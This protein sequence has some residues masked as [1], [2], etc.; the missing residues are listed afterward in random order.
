MSLRSLF[1]SAAVRLMRE[2]WGAK[3]VDI[4]GDERDTGVQELAEEL[5]AMILSEE[6][7]E[8]F[9]PIVLNNNT[10]GPAIVIRQSATAKDPITVIDEDGNEETIQTKDDKDQQDEDDLQE[11]PNLTG[12]AIPGNIVANL[13]GGNYSINLLDGG[14]SAGVSR[15]IVANSRTSARDFAVGTPVTVF[16]GFDGLFWFDGGT[17]QVFPGTVISG[18]EKTYVVQIDES[19]TGAGDLVN[20]EVEQLQ[21]AE[22]QTIPAGTRTLVARSPDGSFYMQL[23][24]FL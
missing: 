6:P 15:R 8:L 14:I 11:N 21:L 17:G 16:Q 10:D 24:V 19:G 4:E 7:I 3:I 12:R 20:V 1:R 22:Q 13:T 23:A 18:T 2:E 9:E 5:Y